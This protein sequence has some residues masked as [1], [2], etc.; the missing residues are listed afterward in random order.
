MTIRRQTLYGE[1][2]S[3]LA[4][5]LNQKIRVMMLAHNLGYVALH[6]GDTRRAAAS[7]KQALQLSRLPDRENFGMC[8][9][10]LGHVYDGRE[11]RPRRPARAGDTELRTLGVALYAPADQLEYDRYRAL[12]LQT[13]TET[14]LPGTMQRVK[15]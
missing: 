6:K 8:L 14:D 12:A 10:G 9:I 4:Q 3:A 1:A 2:P 13:L 5:E 7:F 15:R 11:S